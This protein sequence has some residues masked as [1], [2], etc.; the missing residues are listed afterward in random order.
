VAIEYVPLSSPLHEHTDDVMDTLSRIALRLMIPLALLVA[1]SDAGAQSRRKKPAATAAAATLTS[2]TVR[3]ESGMTVI[4]HTRGTGRQAK[5]GD[6]AVVHY[7]GRLDNDT[8]FDSSVERTPFSF[9]LGKGQVIKGWDE[10][11]AMLRTGDRATLV[12]PA[13]LAYGER[14]LPQIPAN[15]R[16]T[17]E[18]EL[19]ELHEKTVGD[20]I[21]AVLDSEG[22]P[23]AQKL[24]TKLRKD[25]FSGYYLSEDELNRLGY[26]YLGAKKVNEAIAIFRMNVRAFPKSGNVYDSLGEALM[27]SGDNEG[28]IANYKR[29]LELDP[30]NTNAVEML[31][32]LQTPQSAP[33]TG[34]AP[35]A[36]R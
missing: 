18:V 33:Q 31:K 1:V 8:V 13:H 27:A 14:A 32:K 26:E 9:R 24:Y 11:I 5:A 6:L 3:T 7:T 28:A 35:D 22:V 10:G 19:L 21:R 23:A 12:I 25:R 20:T 16:L 15:S 30:K 4:L 36:G 2:D 34:S 17:F 29:S